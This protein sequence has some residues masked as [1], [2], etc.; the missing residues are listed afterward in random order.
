PKMTPRSVRNARILWRRSAVDETRRSPRV[1]M[2]SPH[3]ALRGS[4]S[5]LLLAP[6]VF[7]DDAVPLLDLAEN[8]ERAGHD[9]RAH[10]WTVDDLD[11]QIARQPALDLLELKLAPPDQKNAFL[12]LGTA[13]GSGF[14]VFL[15]HVADDQGLDRNRGRP[16]SAARHDLGGHREARPDR[17]RWLIQT[18]LHLEVDRLGVLRQGEQIR[19]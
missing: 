4:G 6:F 5:R 3:A 15:R 11:H 7:D 18:N 14:L 9:L 1:V 17:L 19:V 10:R 16:L 12:G 13:G 8:L 2:R